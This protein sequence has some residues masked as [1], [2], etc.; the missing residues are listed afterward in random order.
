[1]QE[2]K[3]KKK[4]RNIPTNITI[5]LVNLP[6]YG[7]SNIAA[8][9]AT[10]TQTHKYTDTHTHVSNARTSTDLIKTVSLN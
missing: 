10:N 9:E 2:G 6:V 8:L 7:Y 3:R 5:Y 4:K 1:M